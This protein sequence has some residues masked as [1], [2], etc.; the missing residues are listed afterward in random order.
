M[1]LLVLNSAE[2]NEKK[3]KFIRLFCKNKQK[4]S[5]RL[6]KKKPGRV[7]WKC[8]LYERQMTKIT[9]EASYR[10]HLYV[11]NKLIPKVFPD[12]TA[13]HYFHFFLWIIK[14]SF[15]TL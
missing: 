10:L 12:Y 1:E 3:K 15:L 11:V 6:G 4:G 14:N 7:K 13:S 9:K 2:Q 8:L 5:V